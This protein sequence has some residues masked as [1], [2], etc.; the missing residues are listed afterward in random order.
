MTNKTEK[1][2]PIIRSFSRKQVKF[3]TLQ[4]TFWDKSLR[5]SLQK[6]TDIHDFLEPEAERYSTRPPLNTFF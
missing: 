5:N 2:L 3:Y 4:D 1:S 6:R